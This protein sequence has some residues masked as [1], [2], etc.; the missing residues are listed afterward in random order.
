M[1]PYEDLNYYPNYSTHCLY[2]GEVVTLYRLGKICILGRPRIAV[3][4]NVH[5]ISSKLSLLWYLDRG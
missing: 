4:H 2:F 3:V 1:F 5:C